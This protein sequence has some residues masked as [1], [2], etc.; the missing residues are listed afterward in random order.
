MTL[1]DISIKNSKS[2]SKTFRLYDEKGLYLEVAPSGGKW[3]RLKYRYNGKEKRIS[4]GIYPDVPLKLA[5]E[6]RDEARKLIANKVDPSENKKAQK[7]ANE[8]RAANSFEVVCHEWISRQ[9]EKLTVSHREKIAR[10]FEK[11]IFPWL[12][13]TPIADIKAMDLLPALRRIE[14][15]GAIETAHRILSYCGQVFRYAVITGRADGDPS[16][17]LK[18]ALRTVKGGHFAAIT[19]PSKVGPLLNAIDDYQGSFVVKSALKIAPLV[20]VR[21]GELRHMKW[22]DID[23]DVCEWRYK[24]TKTNTDH[25]V[26]L[27]T[28]SMN[29][30]NEIKPLTQRGVYVFPSPHVSTKPMSDNAILTAFQ[31][32]FKRNPHTKIRNFDTFIK[33]MCK[34]QEIDKEGEISSSSSILKYIDLYDRCEDLPELVSRTNVNLHTCNNLFCLPLYNPEY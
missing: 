27:S 7:R 12:G 33:K 17:D 14:E 30:L 18:G 10:A 6:R 11:D 22:A 34:F 32:G 21:P 24:V 25:I 23:F 26:P 8:D 29:I 3:W 13:E 20:F 4:L 16:K 9:S 15:R 5:R 31:V 1:S 19:D 28:Q 2:Q